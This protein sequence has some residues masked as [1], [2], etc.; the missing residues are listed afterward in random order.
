MDS[1]DIFCF[2]MQTNSVPG[3]YAQNER[4]TFK[5][6]SDLNMRKNVTILKTNENQAS[7]KQTFTKQWRVLRNNIIIVEQSYSELWHS[8]Y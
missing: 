5:F 6:S 4:E 2:S 8:I 3:Y 7:A 1:V